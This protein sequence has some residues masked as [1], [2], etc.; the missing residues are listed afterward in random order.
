M[1]NLRNLPRQKERSQTDLLL[2]KAWVD[3]KHHT[4]NGER[5]LCNVGGHD[6]LPADGSIRLVRG[7]TLEDPLL[8]VR[9]EGGVE[10]DALQLSNLGSEVLHFSPNPLASFLYFLLC[11]R[12]NKW[13][14]GS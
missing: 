1:L 4:I 7:S 12:G 2:G 8:K 10:G 6:N 3:D 13:R 14:K 9:G 11:T 5:S